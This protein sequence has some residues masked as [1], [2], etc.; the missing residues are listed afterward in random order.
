VKKLSKSQQ[1]RGFNESSEIKVEY[2][3]DENEQFITI[4][5]N[6]VSSASTRKISSAID[7]SVSG[8]GEPD[9]KRPR[10]LPS[11]LQGSRI[12]EETIGSFGGGITLSNTGQ[13][14]AATVG[15]VEGLGE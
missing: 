13:G 4:N 8:E 9:A 2:Q 6:L 5:N 15:H 10:A 3:E 14:G 7:I 1:Q 12:R 11:F